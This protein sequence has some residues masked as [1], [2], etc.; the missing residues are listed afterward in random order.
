MNRKID[1][2]LPTLL[3][4]TMA[5]CSFFAIIDETKYF[6]INFGIIQEKQETSVETVEV[7]IQTLMMLKKKQLLKR[8]ILK[9]YILLKMKGMIIQV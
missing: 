1:Y 7:E 6:L 3:I 5:I 4:L 8:L 9:S 2:L